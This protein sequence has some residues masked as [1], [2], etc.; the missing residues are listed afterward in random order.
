GAT[1]ITAT[2]EGQSGTATVSVTTVPVASVTVSPTTVSVQAGQTVQ[3]TATPKDANGTALSGRTVT[4]ASS[5]VGVATVSGGVV[6]GVTAGSV[7]MAAPSGVQGRA[8]P[9]TPDT[10]L[11]A[12][13]RSAG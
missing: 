7:A 1:T 3:L 9:R 8:Q 13:P 6:S 4:W 2:S 10:W 11:T 12:R 5:N